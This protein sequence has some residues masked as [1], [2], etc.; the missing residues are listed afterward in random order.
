MEREPPETETSETVKSVDAS[1]S[2]KV[3]VAVSPELR[4]VRSEL[5]RMRQMCI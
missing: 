5:M 4:D 3:S 1:E 2:V